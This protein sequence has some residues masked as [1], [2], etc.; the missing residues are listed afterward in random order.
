MYKINRQKL[1]KGKEFVHKYDGGILEF[2]EHLNN[3]KPILVNKNEKEALKK[4]VYV[5]AT[6]IM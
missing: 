5:T 3:K 6:K 4:P 1:Q 2:V